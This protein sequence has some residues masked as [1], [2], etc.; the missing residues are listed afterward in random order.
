MVLLLRQWHPHVLHWEREGNH[1]K[2]MS[3][4]EDNIAI[5]D[6]NY[7]DSGDDNDNALQL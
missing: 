4:V 3:A 5:N 6:Q 7:N 1:R 2:E